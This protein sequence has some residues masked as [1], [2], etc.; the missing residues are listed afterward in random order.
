MIPSL[1]LIRIS[2]IFDSY[3]L[4]FFILPPLMSPSYFFLCAPCFLLSLLFFCLIRSSFFHSS[5]KIAI[6]D[7]RFSRWSFTSHVLTLVDYGKH[8]EPDIYSWWNSRCTRCSIA[9]LIQLNR[10]HPRIA[11]IRSS[12]RRGAINTNLSSEFC[13]CDLI[14]KM[15]TNS[16][17]ESC[18]LNKKIPTDTHVSRFYRDWEKLYKYW[19]HLIAYTINKFANSE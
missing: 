17:L 8:H 9:D 15:L 2:T 6:I 13:I 18:I 12:F 10:K 7:P 16:T 14:S 19:I 3:A 11:S 5:L 1:L 4:Y